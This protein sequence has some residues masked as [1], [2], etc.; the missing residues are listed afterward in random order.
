[1]RNLLGGLV[2]VLLLLG[3]ERKSVDPDEQE[4][5][6]AYFPLN[7]GRYY[8]YAVDSVGY[9]VLGVDSAR[10]QLREEVTEMFD[11]LTGTP[12]YRVERFR[13]ADA[14]RP[15]PATP[16]SVWTAQRDEQ[17]ALRTENNTAF[18]RMIFPVVTRA[19][20]D[21]NAFNTAAER[22]A[23]L[24]SVGAE[25]RVGDSLYAATFQVV[26]DGRLEGNRVVAL[27]SN[28]LG[29]RREV[30]TYARNV[31]LVAREVERI[32]YAVDADNLP[33]IPRE[34]G[35]GTI[36]QQTLLEHGQL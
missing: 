33:K 10:Y 35:E 3:C 2:V 12:T 16:D 22:R 15:W 23:M 27:D 1:M 6:F 14:A 25:Q 7:V 20:W 17:K 26:Y 19:A 29:R 28:A 13:R 21:V 24:D 8:V 9:G 11:D 32:R 18:V 34:I 31:G 36:F 4:R 30:W 5:G